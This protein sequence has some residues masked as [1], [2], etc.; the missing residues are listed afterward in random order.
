MNSQYTVQNAKDTNT[1]TG[2]SRYPTYSRLPSMWIDQLS[3]RLGNNRHRADDIWAVVANSLK[4]HMEQTSKHYEMKI[5]P[6][7]LNTQKS[8]APPVRRLKLVI[9]FRDLY[10]NVWMLWFWCSFL[11]NAIN[12][13]WNLCDY[14]RFYI[15]EY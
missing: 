2:K 12:I 5:T 11:V 7:F 3:W 15:I 10:L 1:F 4:G 8:P 13:R 9:L 14:T 6:S